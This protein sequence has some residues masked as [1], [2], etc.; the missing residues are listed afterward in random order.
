M[1]KPSEKSAPIEAVLGKLSG[2]SRTSSIES[3]TCVMC[4]APAQTFRNSISRTEYTISGMCQ[5]CQ[6][7]LFGVD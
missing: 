3:N 2:R 1:S 7:D 5:K 4:G 6:D